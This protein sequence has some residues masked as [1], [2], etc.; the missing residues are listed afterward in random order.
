MTEPGEILESL[1]REG[2]TIWAEGSRIR[3]RAAKGGFTNELKARLTEN[4]TAVLAAWRE[5]AAKHVTSHPAT[6]AQ[7]ALWFLFQESPESASYN[8]V[9]AAR[10]R[11]EIDISA[12]QHACQ[13]LL[14]RHAS[15]RT[16]YAMEATRLTQRI[17]GDMPQFFRVHDRRG[18]D[19]LKLRD[20]V[21]DVSHRPFRLETGPVMRVDL[22]RR[23]EADHI[24]LIT[25]HHIAF[26]GWSGIL[27]LEDLRKN[28]ATERNEGLAP[29]PR[30]ENDVSGYARWQEEML[31]SPE[32][33]SHER[34][35]IELLAGEIPP[36]DL[37]TDRP[38]S[39]V[40]TVSGA[41]FPVELGA[42]VSAAVRALAVSA[43]TTPF[44]V[45]LTAY[46][47]VLHR[48]TGQ[49]Q[50]VVGSPTYGRD[51]SE[52]T[53]V[54]GHFINMIPLKADFSN[55][56][57]FQELLG[58]LRSRV[59]E[60]IQHQDYPF[61][62][63]VEKLRPARDPSRKP[64][65]QT[66]FILQKFKQL[67]GLEGL[68]SHAPGEVS[69]DFAGLT[70]E[71]FPIPQQEGQFD[72]VLELSD[73]SG[74]YQGDFK[75]DSNLY[76]AATVAALSGHY[77]RLLRAIVTSPAT[78]I[79]RLPMLS[80]AE[81]R[82]LLDEWNATTRDYPENVCLHQLIEAQVE[83]TPEAVAV[84]FEGQRLTYRELDARANQL[85]RYLQ[86]RGVTA[87]SLVGICVERSL[88][89]VIGLLGILKAGGAYVPM[90]PSYPKARLAFMLEDSGVS[91]LLTQSHLVHT[92]ASERA[93]IVCLDTD[94]SRIAGEYTDKP[95][96]RAQPENLVYMIYTSGST[97]QPKGA[98]NTHRGIVNR[99][100]WMQDE[101]RFT[102]IDVV[103]QKT[104][105]SF[106]VSV[107]EFFCPLL[108]GARLVIARPGGHQDPTYLTDVIARERITIMHFVPS[109]LRMF[110]EAY[111]LD[112]CGSLRDVICSGEALPPE[113]VK[114]FYERFAAN[115]HNLYGPTEAGVDVTYWPCPRQSDLSVVP[116]GRPVAN[117]QCYILDPQLQLV[118][119]G[120][121][122]ELHLG[123]IQVGRGYHNRPE[124][125]AGKFI[126]DPFG[127][128]AGG[129]LYKTGDL[130]RYLPDGNIEYLGRID[131][132]VKI[133]GFR[134]ELGEIEAALNKHPGIRDAVVIVRE[135]LPGD[136]RLV[137]YLVARDGAAPTADDLS[138]ELRSSL[139]DH[140]VPSAFVLLDYFPL[141]PNGKVDRKALPAPQEIGVRAGREYV[142][143]RTETEAVVAEVFGEVLRLERVGVNDDFFQLGG[144]SLLATRVVSRLRD[145]LKVEVAMRWLFQ[146]PTP[147]KLG[148]YL[149]TVRWVGTQN[150]GNASHSDEGRERLEI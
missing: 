85:A 77:L 70:L 49:S 92:L 100:L 112:R 94:W 104:P 20:E 34:Y 117:T 91:V 41:S 53:N 139:P 59:H 56:P 32:G 55:D 75:Y 86:K 46:H 21:I 47:V 23:A 9:L 50:L 109:M 113:L 127:K 97:G 29:P 122:G 73:L 147:A 107:W 148:E 27:L 42:E 119:I 24:L 118:P 138:R 28:Y 38:R 63:L 4:K 69:A 71:L 80:V 125:T 106:D 45:L 145:R 33:R 67:A 37:P 83:R 135:D 124:L 17:H 64:I 7:R 78:Q 84:A 144:H 108:A 76:S 25:I 137:A 82:Q 96:Q 12:L 10:I 89:M 120:V 87:E 93:E 36:L 98:M 142:A 111:G 13:A 22:F 2:V 99:L 149:D 43:G 95:E 81:E 146:V 62:L 40:A 19:L 130:C 128:K 3:F 52:F 136:P 5:R 30:P 68:F 88:E 116:I 134:I 51:R 16:T 143:P 90:D 126:P 132:Q 121:P 105:F 6:H 115:L 72:L 150:A 110:L 58:Q 79:S 44:V 66:L 26:D 11:S 129:R 8:V 14:D 60:G 48:Y 133:R 18:V 131:H 39:A 61:A 101:Y 140:M 102:S 74:V 65:F 54:I 123:G 35:W 103:L 1:A 114:L 57:T 141:S 15:L 31:V